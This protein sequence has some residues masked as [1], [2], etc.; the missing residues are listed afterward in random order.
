MLDELEKSVDFSLLCAD[1]NDLAVRS[2]GLRVSV[3]AAVMEIAVLMTRTFARI[4]IDKQWCAVG[5]TS[6]QSL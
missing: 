4:A 6:R 1:D 2:L 3:Y 5:I